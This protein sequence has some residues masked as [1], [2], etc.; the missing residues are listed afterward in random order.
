MSLP[1]ILQAVLAALR[2]PGEVVALVKLLSK[3]PEEKRQEIML[4][5]NR[6]MDESSSG[7]R[8]KWEGQ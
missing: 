1:L 7:D 6:W 3:S 2:F 4:S 8:P 5:V